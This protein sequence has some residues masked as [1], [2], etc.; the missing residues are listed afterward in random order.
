MRDTL[1]PDLRGVETIAY[2]QG[3][4]FES[5]QAREHG[6]SPQLLAHH[7][8]RGRFEHVRRG[9]Y[10]IA[11]YPTDEFDEMRRQWFSVGREIAVLSHE[12]ALAAY[13]L[14]DNIPRAVHMLVPRRSRGLRK[15]LGVVIHTRPDEASISTYRLHGILFTTP[16]RTLADVHGLIQHDQWD[17]AYQQALARGLVTKNMVLAEARNKLCV[18]MLKSSDRLDKS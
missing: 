18:Y 14:S 10:R 6:V 3:G 15:P 7:I 4:Y 13:E 16:A 11:G 17:M 9:V 5:A 8:R 2:G 12:S 1:K